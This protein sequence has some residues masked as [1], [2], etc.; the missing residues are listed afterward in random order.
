MSSS[1]TSALGPSDNPW[2]EPSSSS[3]TLGHNHDPTLDEDSFELSADDDEADFQ[4]VEL[5]S[6]PTALPPPPAAATSPIVL[7]PPTPT[8]PRPLSHPPT[9]NRGLTGETERSGGDFNLNPTLKS[10]EGFGGFDAEGMILG[11]LVVNFNHLVR[12]LQVCLIEAHTG[13]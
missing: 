11:V 5:P 13:A 2:G 4:D 12:P 8:A 6:S 3:P 9:L 7:P 1:P 10:P